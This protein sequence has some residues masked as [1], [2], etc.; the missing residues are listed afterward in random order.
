[1]D[2]AQLPAF[3]YHPDPIRSGSVQASDEACK[4]C[5]KARGYIY[6]GPV[7]AEDELDDALCP[8]CIA[9][10][11]AHEKF[12]AEFVDGEAFADDLPQEVMEEITLRTP[13]FNAWQGEQWLACCGQAMAFVEPAGV[14]EIRQR[15]YELE[16]SLM[17]YIVQEMGISGGAAR[18]MLESLDRDAGPTAYVFQ[19]LSCGVN[20]AYVD[21]IFDAAA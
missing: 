2:A 8:W 19:C 13:G 3:K 5:G 17:M 1:M 7:Y 10:G 15:Y 12:D 6:T 11:S 20:R 18:K 9:N 21:G 4:S 16:G 14:K